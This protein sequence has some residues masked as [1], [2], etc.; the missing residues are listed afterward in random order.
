MPLSVSRSYAAVMGKQPELVVRSNRRVQ[1]VRGGFSRSASETEGEGSRV[2][3]RQSESGVTSCQWDCREFRVCREKGFLD[4]R[5]GSGCHLRDLV[6]VIGM[7]RRGK[8]YRVKRHHALRL[9][10]TAVPWV[11]I[12]GEAHRHFD[13]L[14]TPRRGLGYRMMRTLRL[15]TV[16]CGR[17]SGEQGSILLSQSGW[18]GPF[19]EQ[20]SILCGQSRVQGRD[21]PGF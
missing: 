17:P 14:R 9:G 19:G 21:P 15:G 6:L 20:G 4:C 5:P 3:G 12:P 16:P 8:G 1:R 7:P 10:R 11:G 18:G 2:L 13:G